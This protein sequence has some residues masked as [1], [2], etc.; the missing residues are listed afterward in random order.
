MRDETRDRRR[1]E[2]AEAAYAVLAENGYGGASMLAIA[3]RAKA[4]NETLYNWFGDK[5]GLFRMLVEANAEA[6]S[7]VLADS[8]AGGADVAGTLERF[9]TALTAAILGDRAVALNRAAIADGSGELAEA[10]AS[11]GRESL[12][13]LLDGIMSRIEPAGAFRTT[14]E[15]TATYLDLLIG[16]RQIRRVIGRLAA[17]DQT[18]CEALSREALRK[19]R[20][21]LGAASEA[22]LMPSK[23]AA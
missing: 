3:R 11:A 4:S 17:P 13:P 21:L 18:E 19:F 20:L 23:P 8:L 15:M 2:I 7:G 16:D 14:S 12:L 10:L 22:A 5:R 9:G 6:A 1:Q